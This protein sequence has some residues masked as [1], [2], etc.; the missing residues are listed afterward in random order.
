MTVA[1]PDPRWAE[2]GRT[3]VGVLSPLFEAVEHIGSTAVPGLI[4]RPVIDLLAAA[5]DLD[6]INDEALRSYGYRKER[7]LLYWREDYDSLRYELRVVPARTWAARDERQFRN[8]LLAEPAIRE[9]YA[10]VKLDLLDRFG[11]GEAY[12]RGKTEFIRGL[13]R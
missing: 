5:R 8:R 10:A 2:R 11:P 12:T 1:E 7:P 4:A 9:R 3:A 6:A 13:T